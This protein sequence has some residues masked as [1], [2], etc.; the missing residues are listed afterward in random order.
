MDI[1]RYQQ[2]KALFTAAVKLPVAE[3]DAYVEHACVGQPEMLA[4]VRSLLAHHDSRTLLPIEKPA[5]TRGGSTTLGRWTVRLLQPWSRPLI[6]WTGMHWLT[7][8]AF[9]GLV[10]GMAE[11]SWI[12][13]TLRDAE[14][15]RQS[16]QLQSQC[17]EAASA[18]TQVIERD[19]WT[20]QACGTHPEIGRAVQICDELRTDRDEASHARKLADQSRLM[21]QILEAFWGRGVQFQVWNRSNQRIAASRDTGS[22]ID[23]L[24]ID[25]WNPLLAAVIDGR[26][27]VRLPGTS[28]PL[29][30]S[31]PSQPRPPVIEFLVPIRGEQRE[32]TGVLLLHGTGGDQRLQR[33]LAKQTFGASGMAL[34]FARSGEVLTQSPRLDV[35]LSTSNDPASGDTD[36]PVSL[37]SQKRDGVD[38]AVA[39]WLAGEVS[40]QAQLLQQ[41]A[42]GPPGANLQGYDAG[43]NHR[44]AVA[45]Q[46]LDPYDFGIAVEIDQSELLRSLRSLDVGFIFSLGVLLSGFVG[47]MVLVAV[48]QRRLQARERRRL[49][50]Y[51]L[52]E[53]L[54]EG[55]MGQVY[56]AHH[57][58]LKRPTA[59]KVLKPEVVSEAA[60][61]RFT[62]EVQFASR[63]QHPNTVDIYDYGQTHDGRFYYAMECLVGVSLAELV[64]SFGHL[65]P[66]RT[67]YLLQQICGSLREAHQLGLVHRDIKPQ[68]I[69]V[70]VCG[71]EADV[72]KVLDFGLVKEVAAV[73]ADGDT[74]VAEWVGTPRY[75]A[76][77]RV[78]QPAGADPRSDI[79]SCGAVAYWLLTGREVFDNS[80]LETLLSDIVMRPPETM[81]AVAD[82]PERLRDLILRC[83]AKDPLERPQTMIDFQEALTKRQPET[84]WTAA[85]AAAWWRQHLP[86]HWEG[87]PQPASSRRSFVA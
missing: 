83:L 67:V 13:W 33:A 26:S 37:R 2:M 73:G 16:V 75:M 45:W 18:I 32:V 51:V 3:R 66:A 20:A 85:D 55:G 72:V 10:A 35:D 15:F 53:L 24:T 6:P 40:P 81:T 63:L 11:G 52:E 25:Q 30:S 79:Y 22:L 86:D 21:Q 43:T 59:V 19:L 50:P 7:A 74:T 44:R 8:F 41:A 1:D 48:I 14:W 42:T 71:G 38:T 28:R 46:W 65:Q 80:N 47:F 27:L 64:K 54:G 12:Y 82:L 87:I 76:P 61:R 70:C 31:S 57:D 5:K 62:R 34:A 56:K 60:L 9:L 58:L 36:E 69:M 78:L 77:E 84:R 17:R 68:N 39:A 23:E 4:E 49:G 29:P